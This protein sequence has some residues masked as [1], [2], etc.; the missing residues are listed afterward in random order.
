MPGGIAGR[1]DLAPEDGGIPVQGEHREDPDSGNDQ[2]SHQH[3][4]A[5]S[6]P[7]AI[8]PAGFGWRGGDGVLG[9]AWKFM[10]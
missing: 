4:Q 5:E 2:G 10:A 9:V 7:A 1:H 6:D 8:T 3:H